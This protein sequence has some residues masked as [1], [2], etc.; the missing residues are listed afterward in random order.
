MR[1][2]WVK[3]WIWYVP[4]EVSCRP[5]RGA[6]PGKLAALAEAAAH[7]NPTRSR[8]PGLADCGVAAEGFFAGFCVVDYRVGVAGGGGG[9]PRFV[10]GFAGEG[11]QF[12]DPA[13][14]VGGVR[15][16]LPALG[17]RVE[18]A[19]VRRGVRAAARHPL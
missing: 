17:D 1:M 7:S 14:D 8:Q 12:G 5:D 15:V 4:R 18:D 3:S 13:V 6:G 2:R 11:G 19:E 10:G 9:S 16:E